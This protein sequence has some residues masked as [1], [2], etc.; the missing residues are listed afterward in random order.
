MS[1]CSAKKQHALI[2]ACKRAGIAADIRK[3]SS[4][5]NITLTDESG[6][7][8]KVSKDLEIIPVVEYSIDSLIP[9]KRVISNVRSTMGAVRNRVSPLQGRALRAKTRRKSK[10]TNTL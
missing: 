5:S 9:R 1:E 2:E 8:Y 7:K 4:L 6:R 3:T 10:K